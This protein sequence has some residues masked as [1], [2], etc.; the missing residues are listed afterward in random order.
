MEATSNKGLKK[1]IPKDGIDDGQDQDL[2]PESMAEKIIPSLSKD[3][4]WSP[5]MDGIIPTEMIQSITKH[6]QS[7][8]K[9]KT[10]SKTKEERGNNKTMT[11][12]AVNRHIDTILYGPKKKR[13]LPVF[14]QIL[15]REGDF[16]EKD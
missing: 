10:K 9:T 8:D 3:G 12:N 16:K 7:M 14:E 13:C 6:Y 11:D 15:R 4:D 1:K 2:S 5:S